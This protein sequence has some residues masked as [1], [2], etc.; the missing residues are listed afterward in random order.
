LIRSVKV[1]F[2]AVSLGRVWFLVVEG[3]LDCINYIGNA[4]GEVD[5]IF[6]W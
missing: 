2:L 5:G 6:V 1:K 3:I 4:L